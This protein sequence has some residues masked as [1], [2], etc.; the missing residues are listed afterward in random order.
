MEPIPKADEM[1]LGGYQPQQA[2]YN[3]SNLYGESERGV[4]TMIV[5]SHGGSNVS[6]IGSWDNWST[7][8][9]SVLALALALFCSLAHSRT[10]L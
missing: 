5:W 9:T 10:G 6:V 8:Y 3:D 1:R 2:T 7:R 4:A